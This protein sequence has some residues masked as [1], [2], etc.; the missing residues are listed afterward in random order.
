MK[1]LITILSSAII[2]VGIMASIPLFATSCGKS[3]AKISGFALP[4]GLAGETGS[5]TYTINTTGTPT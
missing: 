5:A 1:K 4:I 3:S 2:S